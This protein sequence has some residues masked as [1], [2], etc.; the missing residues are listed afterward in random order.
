LVV[1]PLVFAGPSFGAPDSFNAQARSR[2]RKPKPCPDQ[3]YVVQGSP[4]LPGDSASEAFVISNK[5]I[6]LGTECALSPAKLRVTPHGTKIKARWSS[7]TGLQGKVKLVASIDPACEVM[8]G[9]IKALRSSLRTNFN[10]RHSGCGDVGDPCNAGAVVTVNTTTDTLGDGLCSFQEAVQAA[11]S[12]AVVD[13]CPAGMPSANNTIAFNIPGSGIQTITATSVIQITSP[14]TIDGSTQP[15]YA[16]VPLIHITG[17]VEDL[18]RFSIEANGSSLKDLMLTNT[19]S[20][21]LTD[22]ATALF[23]SNNNLIIGNYFNT[24]GAAVVGPHGAGLLFDTSA[25]N[26][27]GGATPAT[28][29]VFG[30]QT[31]VYL[32]D[33]SHNVVE[34]NYFG[35]QPDGNSAMGGLPG[36]G[37]GI[38]IF[39]VSGNATANAIQGNVIAGFLAG[40]Q[41]TQGANANVVRRNYVGVGVDGLT[42][43][44]NGIGVFVYGAPD[45][46]IGGAAMADRNVISGNSSTNITLQNYDQYRADNNVI[47]GNYIGPDATGTGSVNPNALFGV[48]IVG[49]AGGSVIS[50]NVI[51]GNLQGIYIDETSTVGSGSSQNC[52]NGN[53]TY[54]VHNLNTVSAPFANN[55]WGDASGPRYTGQAVGVGDWVSANV[56]FSPFLISKP[57]MCTGSSP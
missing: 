35:V 2:R 28:R 24:D 41:L 4:V 7:C 45:N 39:D 1:L 27:I 42:A 10:A 17:V 34:G 49:G 6:S 32:Q 13:A 33:S 31:G 36:K 53:P 14:I 19:N 9:T 11:N 12:G 50:G 38:E 8:K 43:H 29:N 30:G 44:G 48:Y 21:G 16:G 5:H 57:A 18:L 22:G 37:S 52:I 55:W 40:I 23:Y 46:T 51:A 54:G 26:M 25:N 47:E 56:T 15:G 20:G 3:R